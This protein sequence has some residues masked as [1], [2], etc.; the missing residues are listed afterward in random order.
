M[1]LEKEPIIFYYNNT[2]LYDEKQKPLFIE[3][4]N[5]IEKKDKDGKTLLSGIFKLRNEVSSQPT[6]L[7]RKMLEMAGFP[8]EYWSTKSKKGSALR[9]YSVLTTHLNGKLY[10]LE[11]L[12]PAD[13]RKAHI[14][15]K[16]KKRPREYDDVL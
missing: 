3:W 5:V 12:F 9:P 15:K 2:K 6:R 16:P 14:P 4:I 8:K 10:R 13:T 1:N 7:V 11:D